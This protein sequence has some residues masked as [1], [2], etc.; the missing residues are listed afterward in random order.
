MELLHGICNLS[1]V[2][3]RAEPSDRSEMITQLL[4]GE[5]FT[6][7]RSQG[8]WSYVRSAIDG[9]EAWIDQKQFMPISAESFEELDTRPV[10]CVLDLLSVMEDTDKGRL[11]P[12]S[13]G[14]L[15]PLFDGRTCNLEGYEFA[16]EGQANTSIPENK[17]ELMLEI[18][19]SFLGAPYLWGGK[20]AFGI[21]CSGFVQI[22]ARTVGIRLSRDA[23]Q[24]AE[25]GQTLG[26]I[27]ETL[28]GD[29][30]FFDNEDGR[31]VH[32]GLLMGDQKIIHASG[33]VRIDRIDH[34]GI[35]N[36]ETGRYTHRLR[37]LKRIL[38]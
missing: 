33:K 9:Y 21:D 36:E 22:I 18:A 3:C 16:F 6:I 20:S 15:L 14:S 35:F 34:E 32:V 13:L 28:P 5:H 17:A 37:L 19:A 12:V 27:E 1:V 29:I 23:Y 38:S 4:F 30:A 25:H 11:F 24:Q 2:P 10:P 7:I 8:N 26:F 31:I